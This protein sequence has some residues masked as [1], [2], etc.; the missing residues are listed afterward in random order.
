MARRDQLVSQTMARLLGGV[1]GGGGDGTRAS[2]APF[3]RLGA[4]LSAGAICLRQPTLLCLIIFMSTNSGF[5]RP[6][7]SHLE[8]NTPHPP[9]PPPLLCGGS[10]LFFFLSKCHSDCHSCSKEMRPVMRLAERFNASVSLSSLALTSSF[11]LA[12]QKLIP[13]SAR[14]IRALFSGSSLRSVA[15][16]SA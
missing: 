7:F 15:L 14:N 6:L 3:R 4:S 13:V 9:P 2:L 5:I 10:L 16:N 8:E 1:R 11:S 12:H